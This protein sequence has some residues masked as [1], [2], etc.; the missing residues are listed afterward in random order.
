M[1]SEKKA[2]N[3]LIDER[4]KVSSHYFI[5]RNGEIILMVPDLYMAWH[6]GVSQWKGISNLNNNSIGIE[7]ENPG[8]EFGYIPF[9]KKQMDAL[10][11]LCKKLRPLGPSEILQ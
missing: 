1:K 11:S 4:S 8:H 10:I 2:I 7:L 9:S 5:K 6:A 3:K